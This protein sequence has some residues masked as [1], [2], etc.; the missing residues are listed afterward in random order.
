MSTMDDDGIPTY[1]PAK[2][3]GWT[4]HFRN[5]DY[6]LSIHH[7]ANLWLLVK[8]VQPE[9]LLAERCDYFSVQWWKSSHFWP[10][11]KYKNLTMADYIKYVVAKDTVY[12]MRNHKYIRNWKIS[13][14]LTSIFCILYV[15]TKLCSPMRSLW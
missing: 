9:E 10:S 4:L 12:K 15:A 6:S 7:N 11:V 14:P 1:S 8:Q 5:F 3:G 2:Q 13:Q